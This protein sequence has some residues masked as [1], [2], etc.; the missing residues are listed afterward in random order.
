M[1]TDA[2]ADDFLTQKQPLIN[3]LTELRNRLLYCLTII[4]LLFSGLF[5]YAGDLYA[6]ISEPL[7]VHLPPGTSMIATDVAAPFLTPFKLSLIV[8]IVLAVPF[9]F[10]QNV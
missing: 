6:L 4:G 5:F 9:I 8:A 7:R 1:M 10:Y 3:H 2:A